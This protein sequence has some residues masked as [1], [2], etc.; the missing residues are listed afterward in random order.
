MQTELMGGLAGDE[1]AHLSS[2]QLD[3][4]RERVRAWAAAQI[5]EPGALG[6]SLMQWFCAIRGLLQ[7]MGN[8]HARFVGMGMVLSRLWLSLRGCG[9]GPEWQL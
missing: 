1:A 8:M 7:A 6:T 4:E 2:L 5:P 9:H 3:P